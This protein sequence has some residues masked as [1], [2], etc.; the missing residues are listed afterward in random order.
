[1]TVTKKNSAQHLHEGLSQL[2]S[3]PRQPRV[4]QRP[5]ATPDP[6]ITGNQ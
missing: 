2:R 6:F 4:E 1:M 5:G 3:R